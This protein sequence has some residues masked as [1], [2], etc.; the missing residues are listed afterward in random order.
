MIHLDH[1]VTMAPSLLLLPFPPKSLKPE[2][3]DVAYRPSITSAIKAV[4]SPTSSSTLIVAVPYTIL[5]G[6]TRTGRQISWPECQL[7]LATLY[8]IVSLVSSGLSVPSEVNGGATAVDTRIVL[9][10]HSK[11]VD[12]NTLCKPIVVQN[13]TTIIDLPTFT[14][15]YHPWDRI[16]YVDS[17]MGT[18]FFKRFCKLAEWKQKLRLSSFVQVPGGIVM[19]ASAPRA[20]PCLTRAHRVVCLGGTFDYLHPGHKLLL[21]T[22]VQLLDVP[23]PESGKPCRLI[24][25]ITGD[26]LLANKKFADQ[27]QSWD[28]RMVNVFDFLGT[29]LELSPSGFGS[30]GRPELSGPPARANFR[31]GTILVECVEINDVYGPTITDPEIT[32]LVVSGETKAGGDDV[33]ARRMGKGFGLMELFVVDVLDSQSLVRAGKVSGFDSKISSTTI[34]ERRAAQASAQAKF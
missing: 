26:A 18:L 27:V 17:E 3:L 32:A 7:L 13:S 20:Q 21:T 6:L 30:Q 28:E 9:V 33:L 11:D 1:D 4:S 31:D 29:L 19:Q 14:A 10:D 12:P 15:A 25:G 23:K 16:F 24:I 2:L 22:A 34:R 5:H 8:S